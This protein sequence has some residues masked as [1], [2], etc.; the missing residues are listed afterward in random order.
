MYA[1][2]AKTVSVCADA[3][4]FFA[5]N[6]FETPVVKVLPNCAK[7]FSGRAPAYQHRCHRIFTQRFTYPRM[8]APCGQN[9]DMFI[10]ELGHISLDHIL[11]EDIE[12]CWGRCSIANVHSSIPRGLRILQAS[13]KCSLDDCVVRHSG[14]AVNPLEFFVH[15]VED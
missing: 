2:V 9:T 13:V 4:F 1:S 11:S 5:Y 12:P 6:V 3:Y 14:N 15:S 10:A 8:C 7:D